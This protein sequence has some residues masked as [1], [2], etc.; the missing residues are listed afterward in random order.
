[1]KD[2]AQRIEN[3]NLLYIHGLNSSANYLIAVMS[4]KRSMAHK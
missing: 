3:K 4:S 1:M 2:L